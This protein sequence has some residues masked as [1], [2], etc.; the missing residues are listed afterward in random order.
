MKQISLSNL[1]PDGSSRFYVMTFLLKILYKNV[2]KDRIKVLDVGGASPYMEEA[3]N[4]LGFDG[5]L[6]IIDKLPLPKG[7]KSS[8]YTQ[9]DA[10][11]MPFSD[12][13]F[14]VVIS[15]DVLEHIETRSKLKFI[16][17]CL[18]VAKSYVIIA[19][20]FETAGVDQSERSVNR[21][22]QNLFGHG[23]E[24]LEEHFLYKKPKINEIEDYLKKEG[25][26]WDI[27]GAGNLYLWL[28]SACANLMEAKLGIDREKHEELNKIFGHEILLSGEMNPP[29]YR[30][31]LVVYKNIPNAFLREE[32]QINDNKDLN[33]RAG[34]NYV[35]GLMALLS[36]HMQNQ[37][38]EIKELTLKVSKLNASSLKEQNR[39][40]VEELRNSQVKL[41]EQEKIITQCYPYIHFLE[42]APMKLIQKVLR[43]LTSRRSVAQKSI[44]T[45]EEKN[46]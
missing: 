39:M 13:S 21:L 43:M 9:S 30:H 29:Y 18:R 38:N 10:N 7:V 11:N 33:H 22:N 16:E 25:F 2:P 6:S 37:N 17:E 45:N 5:E 28:V 36:E 14:D 24:W 42:T 4:K 44:N 46:K 20:P 34:L 40:L 26:K 41:D 19:A 31:F 32:I 3:F 35:S 27:L 8:S 1:S 15:T 12:K 23:Q